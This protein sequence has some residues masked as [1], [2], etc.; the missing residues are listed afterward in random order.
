MFAAEAAIFLEFKPLRRFLLILVRHVIAV[1]AI[2]TLQ[3]DIVS[4]MFNID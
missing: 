3:N 4:H 2:T 1:F